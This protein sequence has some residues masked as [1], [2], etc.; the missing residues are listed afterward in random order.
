[1]RVPEEGRGPGQTPGDGVE[2]CPLS[3]DLTVV[4]E[5]PMRGGRMLPPLDRHGPI[6]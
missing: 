2:G 4:C 1:M 5:S 3:M 6:V